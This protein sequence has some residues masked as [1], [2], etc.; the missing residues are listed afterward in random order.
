MKSLSLVI[1]GYGTV[2]PPPNIPSGAAAPENT[3]KTFIS[4]FLVIG[5]AAAVIFVAYGGVLW[6]MSSGDKGK[7]D[8]ARRT[9]TF[10][11]V[12]LIVMLLA[13]VIVQTIGYILGSDYLSNL[14]K[15]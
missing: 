14:G 9:I 8:R 3:I 7:L 5:M 6:V 13:F 10:S 1:P 15:Y 2:T 12:G 11:I 4:L